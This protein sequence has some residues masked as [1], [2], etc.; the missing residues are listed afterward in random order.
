VSESE[1]T[2]S[3]GITHEFHDA[4]GVFQFLRDLGY[5][6]FD[7]PPVIFYE[8][9]LDQAKIAVM[10]SARLMKALLTFGYVEQRQPWTESS[11]LIVP[12]RGVKIVWGHEYRMGG[13]NMHGQIFCEGL[14]LIRSQGKTISA[15][16]LK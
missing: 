4:N 16:K 5:D 7:S 1:W 2:F 10:S 9:L 6:F 11:N 13:C 12:K 15:L 8:S 3:N 14:D